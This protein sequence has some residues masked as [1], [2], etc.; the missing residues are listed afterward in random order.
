MINNNNIISIKG[1]NIQKNIA[2][3][4]IKTIN[5]WTTI[6]TPIKKILII[7]PTILE[8]TLDTKLLKNSPGLN[9]FG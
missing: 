6:P 1:I 4:P 5:S 3:K 7:A 2:I 9:P 8:K